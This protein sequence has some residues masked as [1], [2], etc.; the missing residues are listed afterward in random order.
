MKWKIS[1]Y[2]VAV[3]EKIKKWPKGILAKYLRIVDLIYDHGAQLGKPYTEVI[4]D[5]LFE[6]RVKG[7]EG[8]ARAFFCYATKAEIIILHSFIKKT[9]KT[10]KKE[11][12]IAKER[13]K[14]VKKY[15]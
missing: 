11:L 4:G 7:K 8:I 5:G 12:E 14:E 3:I 9:Q 13:L 15:E 2:S 10:P 6:I 1:Y